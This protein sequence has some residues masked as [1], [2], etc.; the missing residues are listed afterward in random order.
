MEQGFPERLEAVQD[1]VRDACLRTGRDPGEV[2][3]VAVTKTIGPDAVRQAA[4]AGLRV[5]GENRVQEA[6]QK[7]PLCPGNIEWHMVGHL[8]TNKV[9]DAVA[10]FTMIHSVDS[11]RLLTAV[12]AASAAAGKVTSVCLEVNA[13]GESSKFGLSPEEV[14]A[15]LEQAGSLMNVDVVGLMTIPP[16]SGEPENARPFFRQLRELRERCQSFFPGGAAE[17]SMGMSGDFAVAVEEGATWIRL[18]TVLFGKRRSAR[19]A[20]GGG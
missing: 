11:L 15:V 20:D 17:L 4:E 2:R 14:P 18:G 8:Q 13:A 12:A 5:F 9:R 1:R 7:I 16:L 19:S 6:R 10:L 3:I